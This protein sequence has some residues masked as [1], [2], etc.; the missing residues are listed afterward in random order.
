MSQDKRDILRRVRAFAGSQRRDA[1][2]LG[3]LKARRGAPGDALFLGRRGGDRPSS[4]LDRARAVAE[5]RRDLAS[6]G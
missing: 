1:M 2:R 6:A 5:V 4:C 3:V